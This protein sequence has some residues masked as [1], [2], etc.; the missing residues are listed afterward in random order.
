MLHLCTALKIPR[1][2]A[3]LPH[4]GL[5]SAQLSTFVKNGAFYKVEEDPIKFFGVVAEEGDS[6]D[7][8]GFG[9]GP[10]IHGVGGKYGSNAQMQVYPG[11][12]ITIRYQP[13]N[14][15]LSITGIALA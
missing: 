6:D 3:R 4:W 15:M 10:R 13:S 5:T 8:D 12:K 7:P 14:M 11:S 2:D 9:P 1:Y